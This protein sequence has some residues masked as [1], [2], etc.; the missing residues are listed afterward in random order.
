MFMPYERSVRPRDRPHSS[1]QRYGQFVEDYRRHRL[2]ELNEHQRRLA[3]PAAD[4]V[5]A[6]VILLMDDGRVIERG[7]HAALT[8]N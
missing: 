8:Q 6:D 1:R 2:D 3:S 4:A 5:D 7:A